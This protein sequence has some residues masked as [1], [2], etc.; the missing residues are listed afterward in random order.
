MQTPTGCQLQALQGEGTVPRVPGYLRTGQRLR[1]LPRP[2]TGA[3]SLDRVPA[4]GEASSEIPTPGP[5]EGFCNTGGGTCPALLPGPHDMQ[6]LAV[7]ALP[8]GGL[9]QQAE[10]SKPIA[11]VPQLHGFL[12]LLVRR[13]PRYCTGRA[14]GAGDDTCTAPRRLPWAEAPSA[15]SATALLGTVAGTG[16]ERGSRS[17]KQGFLQSCL[18]LRG[19]SRNPGGGWKNIAR[20]A[21]V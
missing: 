13:A 15:A 4:G 8:Q 16:G 21:D 3:G 9:A 17:R 18:R 7:R 2:R 11:E 1:V 20:Y 5:A 10:V 19:H 12:R 14:R 6:L